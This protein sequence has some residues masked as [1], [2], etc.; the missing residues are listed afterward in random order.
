MAKQFGG[1]WTEKKLTVLEHYLESY[2]TAMKHHRDYFKLAYIDAFAGDGS[3]HVQTKIGSPSSLFTDILP[4]ADPEVSDLIRGSARRALSLDPGF[5]TYIFIEKDPNAIKELKRLKHEYPERKTVIKEGDAN[6]HLQ[7]L[8]KK[9]W[10]KRRAVVFLDPAGMQVHWNTMEALAST[11]AVD[12]WVWFP[13]GVAV[14]RLLTKDGKFMPG[15]EEILN[16]IFGTPEWKKAFYEEY[17]VYNLFSQTFEKRR[18]K[19]ANFGSIAAFYNNRLRSIFPEVA[20]NPR[21]MTNSRNN[22]IYLLCFA[23]ANEKG[24]KIASR[25]AQHILRRA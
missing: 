4:T 5:D 24:A 14:N 3:I 16:Q 6:Y 21:L 23:C 2:L 11:Q 19:T 8:C 9:D 18:V 20:P 17:E 1:N 22:P 13:I 10:S 25:I 7:N 12:V 15:W